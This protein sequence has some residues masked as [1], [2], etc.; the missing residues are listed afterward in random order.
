MLLDA[1]AGRPLEHGLRRTHD[2]GPLS[3]AMLGLLH[4]VRRCQAGSVFVGQ[5]ALAQSPDVCRFGSA[6][7]VTPSAC[8]K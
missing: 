4:N 3:P 2:S 5:S 6:C 8:L 1:I 7:C